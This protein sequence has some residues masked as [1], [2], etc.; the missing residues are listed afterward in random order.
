MWMTVLSFLKNPKVLIGAGLVV[1]IAVAGWQAYR[2]VYNSGYRDAELQYERAYREALDGA[3]AEARENWELAAA[4]AEKEVRIETEIVERIR[5][6]ERDVPRV[7]V[8]TVP[9]ECRDLGDGVR[10]VFNQA[11]TAGGDHERSDATFTP[12]PGS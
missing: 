8:R 11:I 12:D 3:L 1:T 10:R 7:V 2:H 4:A 5:V 9:A 6:V